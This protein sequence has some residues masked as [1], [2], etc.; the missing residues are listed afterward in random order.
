M[1]WPTRPS[2]GQVDLIDIYSTDAKVGRYR[3]RVLRDDRA[4]FPRYDAVLLMRAS[5]DV[6]ALAPLEG[7]IDERTMMAMNAQV[8]L[9]GRS[10]ADAA[11]GFVAGT[12]AQGGARQGF[13]QLGTTSSLRENWSYLPSLTWRHDGPVWKA[14]A[15]AAY[16][17]AR[18]RT[19]NLQDGLFGTTTSRRGNVTVSFE[20]VS[21]LRPGRITVADGTTGAPIDPFSIGNYVVTAA[22][23]SMRATD[24][25]RRSVFAK[26][27]ARLNFGGLIAAREAQRVL[28][29]LAVEAGVDWVQRSLHAGCSR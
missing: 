19:R 18:N 1:A 27:A 24:D 29:R 2:S 5:L 17:R 8:E 16:A 11:R 26:F 10:F 22:N 4:H 23:G 20:D 6:R 12:V 21:Y 3:L 13:V 25:T 28:D 7:R 14:E 9:D 15:G